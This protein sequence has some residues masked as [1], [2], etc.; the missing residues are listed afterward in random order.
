MN[1]R[2]RRRTTTRASA[3]RSDPDAEAASID[4]AFDVDA[5][6]ILCGPIL[7]GQAELVSLPT[8]G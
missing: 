7:T 3:A 6:R 5:Y 4:P 8:P 2:N 1:R